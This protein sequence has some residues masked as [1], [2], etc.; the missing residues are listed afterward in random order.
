MP[1]AIQAISS[2]P[3]L[4]RAIEEV[5]A[6]AADFAVLPTASNEEEALSQRD[7]SRLFLLDA[8]SLRTDLGA[9]VRRCR[10]YSP[11][12]KFLALLP[13][14]EDNHL[15]KVQ[16]FYCGIDGFVELH[17]AWQTE[18]LL[19]IRS[20][21]SGEYWV[22]DDV[23]RTFV[24]QTKALQ[25]IQLLP[26]HSLAA[27]EAQIVN[28]LARRLTNRAISKLLGISER[29]VKFHVSNILAKLGIEDRHALF[30]HNVGTSRGQTR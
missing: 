18:L 21:V 27:R 30:P 12:S 26:G 14:A 15:D 11:A 16:L 7:I 22:P 6:D 8:F 5:L 28:L 24:E 9:V 17:E 10:V 23:L 29:T 3:L 25:D 13:P 1:L 4:I 19:A 2:H 20:I